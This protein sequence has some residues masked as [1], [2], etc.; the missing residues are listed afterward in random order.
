M[1]QYEVDLCRTLR[2][3]QDGHMKLGH[4]G[5]AAQLTK[6]IEKAEK[7]TKEHTLMRDTM[8]FIRDECDRGDERISP[9]IANALKDLEAR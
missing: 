4:R 8:L 9:A 6:V 7:L 3:I 2:S 1:S 5:M